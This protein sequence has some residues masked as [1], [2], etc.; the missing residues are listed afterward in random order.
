MCY[1]QVLLSIEELD[2]TLRDMQ[3]TIA[4]MKKTHQKFHPIIRRAVSYP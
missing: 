1:P 2:S 3:N 4:R